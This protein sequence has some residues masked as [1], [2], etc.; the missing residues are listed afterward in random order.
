M[1]IDASGH[2]RIEAAVQAAEA[3]TSAEIVCVLARSSSDD[4]QAPLVWAAAIALTTPWP[5]IAFTQWS[6]ERIFLVQLG[7]FVLATLALSLPVVRT[8]LLP[9]AAMRARAERAAREQ[10]HLCGLARTRKR[11]GV[12]IFV[13]MQERYARIIA[14]EGIAAHVPASHWRHAVNLLTRHIK[15]GD[16]A[17]GFVAAI[18]HCAPLLATHFPPEPGDRNELP[19]RVRLT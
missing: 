8:H 13:S 5:L 6:A 12:L 17:S 3:K 19:D 7:V 16:I 9:R 2:Q 11:T 1:A 10:F 14:D 4:T 15:D 18:E